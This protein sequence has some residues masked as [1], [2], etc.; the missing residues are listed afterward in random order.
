MAVL[1][2]LAAKEAGFTATS[3]TMVRLAQH[4]GRNLSSTI[5][6]HDLDSYPPS[7]LEDIVKRFANGGVNAE[8]ALG[9][10]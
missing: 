10:H 5:R 4:T 2:P 6:V 8:R 3:T 7:P 1:A 9:P